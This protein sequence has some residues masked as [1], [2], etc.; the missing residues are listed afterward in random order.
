MQPAPAPKKGDVEEKIDAAI[1]AID[2]AL[3]V[4]HKKIAAAQAGDARALT[5]SPANGAN[6]TRTQRA[7]SKIAKEMTDTDSFDIAELRAERERQDA[8]QASARLKKA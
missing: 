8:R 1:D 3:P 7:L 5:P 6:F 2:A 4:L